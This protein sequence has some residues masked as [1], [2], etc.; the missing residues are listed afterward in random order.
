MVKQFIFQGPKR[1]GLHCF[2]SLTSWHSNVHYL[3]LSVV[4]QIHCYLRKSAKDSIFTANEIVDKCSEELSRWSVECGT[5]NLKLT[6][7]GLIDVKY[8][9]GIVLYFHFN[10]QEQ[11]SLTKE[12][13]DSGQMSRIVKAD[14]NSLLATN[15]ISVMLKWS[16]DN[17]KRCDILLLKRPCSETNVKNC[18]LF[19]LIKIQVRCK[20]F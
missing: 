12:I 5:C 18:L 20:V 10:N 4:G 3:H 1:P 19:S 2:I 7:N 9:N 17:C 14:F 13:F 6:E 15:H 11:L 16:T 8:D